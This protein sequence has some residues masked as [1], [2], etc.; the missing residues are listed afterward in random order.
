[1]EN[2]QAKQTSYTKEIICP[3]SMNRRVIGHNITRAYYVDE[4]LVQVQSIQFRP[5]L[6]LQNGKGDG[7]S[8]QQ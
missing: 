2:K 5:I 3:V 8:S 1:M 4:K 7:S 6:E